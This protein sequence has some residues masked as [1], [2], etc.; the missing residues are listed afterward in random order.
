[1]FLTAGR[2][3]RISRGFYIHGDAVQ[4]YSHD[5]FTVGQKQLLLAEPTVQNCKTLARGSIP[6]VAAASKRFAEKFR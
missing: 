6:L 3:C 1:L 2:F 5:G 4:E